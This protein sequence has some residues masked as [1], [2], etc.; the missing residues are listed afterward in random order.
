MLIQ[1][2][3][4]SLESVFSSVLREIPVTVGT[5]NYSDSIMGNLNLSHLITTMSSVSWEEGLWK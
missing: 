3:M 5:Y 4:T 1:Y 2:V